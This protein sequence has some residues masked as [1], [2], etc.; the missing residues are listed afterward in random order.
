MM[1]RLDG[2]GLLNALR[3]DPATRAI[4]VILLSARAGEESRVEG[5]EAGADDYLV[6]PFS[7]RELLARVGAN[8]EMAR[9]RREAGERVT[10]LME[11]IPDGLITLDRE[12]RVYLRQHPG[13][14]PARPAALGLARQ[15]RLGR[16]PVRGGHRG[17]AAVAPGGGRAG[18]VRVRGSRRRPGAVVREQGL[19]HARGGRRRL[20][21]RHHRAPV[22][23]GSLTPERGAVPAVLRPRADRHGDHLAGQG[24]SGGQRRDL[25]DLRLHARRI[26]AEDVGRDDP[27]GRPGRRRR[28]VRPGHGR[29]GR[30]LHDGQAVDPQGRPDH[31]HHHLGEVRAARGRVGRLL[32][33]AGP[34]RHREEAGRGGPAAERGATGRGPADRPHRQLE[35][36][37]RERRDRLV[38]RA[39][40]HRRPAAAGDSDDG[41]TGRE[42]YPPGRPRG[43]PGGSKA[44]DPGPS[45]LRVVPA[46]GPRGRDNHHRPVA[47]TGGL[48]RGRQ[49]RADVRHDPGR[50]RA[51]AGRGGAAPGRAGAGQRRRLGRRHRHGGDHYVLE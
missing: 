18:D 13:R 45:A 3:A 33:G 36:G 2:F 17:G 7:A 22:R 23:R 15:V 41:R 9:V 27:P 43:R 37:P 10:H 11:S 20:F 47:G 40:P 5:L 16:V 24:L 48:R 42:L 1:P 31:R 26:P 51:D 25:S 4:P 30:R 6:K 49:A 8:L 50:H 35:L 39:L 44:G 12:W 29:G 14:A 28:P 38:G 21:P 32:R 46:H 34:G 19:P